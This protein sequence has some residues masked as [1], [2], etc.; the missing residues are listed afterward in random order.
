MLSNNKTITVTQEAYNALLKEKK[1]SETLSDVILR[2]T[3]N[4]NKTQFSRRLVTEQEMRNNFGE[5]WFS[6]SDLL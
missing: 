2:L 6:D 3:K 4:N 5:G 1:G